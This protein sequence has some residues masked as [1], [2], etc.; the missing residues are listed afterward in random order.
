[1]MNRPLKISDIMT[2]AAEIYP[3]VEVVS[4]R[5][6]GDVHK[7]NYLE[8]SKRIA[9]LGHGLKALGINT[10]DRVA[11]LA[12]NGYRHLELYYAISGIG[13][14]CHTIN[15]RLSKNQLIYIINHAKDKVIFVDLEFVK[16]IENVRE[17]L[18][19]GIKIV[20]LTERKHMPITSLEAECYE[21]LISDKSKKFEWPDF[22]ETT[23]ASLCYTSGTTGEPKGTLYT[24]RSTVLHAMMIS[25]SLSDSLKEGR[26]VLP[27]VPLFHVNAWGLPYAAPLTG[28]GIVF[29]G[30][31]L[32]GDSLYKLMESEQV[33]SAWGV[34]TVWLSLLKTISH[35]NKAPSGFGDVVIGGSSAP[36]SMIETFEKLN[37]NVC[38]AWGMTEM[39]PVGTQGNIPHN[40][41]DLNLEKKLDI[42]SKHGRRIFGVELKIVDKDGKV[43][44]HDGFT[45][46]DLY[47]QGHAITAG[48]FNNEAA[49]IDAFDSDGWFSTGDIATIDCDGYLTI[50]DRSKDLIKSG[51]EWISSIDLENIAMS[52][53]NILNCSAIA[54]PHPTWGE[55]PILIVIPVEGTQLEKNSIINLLKTHF[56][57]WQIPDDIIFVEKL[58]LTATGKVS[59]LTLRGEY[60]N[61][62]LEP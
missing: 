9:Q 31:K 42:K 57:K 6:E 37:I 10:G 56:S 22:K 41:K 19:P 52:H 60:E 12:W 43:L 28:A 54:A 38:H 14:I 16:L 62:F 5:S 47:V 24:H 55:R 34:P 21:E 1:M 61:F 45:Q 35:R 2:F 36:R 20:V 48:Y 46:G 51:G 44:P 32:D 25:I 39:S 59:K 29:P 53:P 30:P 4:V 23:A 26:K 50:V 17:H 49:N 33:Y 11:T 15:P 40:L 18:L 13:G 58:P 8:I 3:T 7:I 27:V